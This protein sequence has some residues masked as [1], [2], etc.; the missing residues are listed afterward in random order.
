MKY[1][2]RTELTDID[3]AKINRKY[4]CSSDKY[5]LG[6]HIP[7]AVPFEDFTIIKNNQ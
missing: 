3:I 4:K 7:N 5:S 1:V 2:K 6:D